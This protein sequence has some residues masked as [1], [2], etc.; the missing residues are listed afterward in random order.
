MIKCEISKVSI[1][2]NNILYIEIEKDKYFG[3]RDYKEIRLAAKRLGQDKELYS[4]INFG[5]KTVLDIASREACQTD[6]G[7]GKIKAEAIIIHSLSQR[8]VAKHI[9]KTKSKLIP[10]KLFS[11]VEKAKAWIHQMKIEISKN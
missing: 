7:N 11:N 2:E 8:I 9:L 10:V 4:L 5:D 3:L 6:T 1:L